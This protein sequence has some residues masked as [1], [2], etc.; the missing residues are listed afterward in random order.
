VF[1]VFLDLAIKAVVGLD[2]AT[3]RAGF[4]DFFFSL[5]IL[6]IVFWRFF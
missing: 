4:L 3:L 2:L 5:S 6:G 1:L